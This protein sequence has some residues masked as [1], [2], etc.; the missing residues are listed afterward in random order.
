MVK[1]NNNYDSFDSKYW[2]T[3]TGVPMWKT[4]KDVPYLQ[5]ADGNF[6]E[7]INF[8]VD[9]AT[10][11]L[12]FVAGVISSSG[13]S[14]PIISC[15]N[16]NVVINGNIITVNPGVY[17]ATIYVSTPDALTTNAYEVVVDTSVPVLFGEKVYIDKST[18]KIFFNE[19]STPD[20]VAT[21][22]TSIIPDTQKSNEQATFKV[23]VGDVK[24]K[25][26]NAWVYDGIFENTHESR[27]RFVETFTWDSKTITGYYILL[28]NIKFDH[29]T[30]A[31]GAFD[32]SETFALNYQSRRPQA[33]IFMAT[34]DGRGYALED[35]GV[36]KWH[37]GIFGNIGDGAVIKNIAIKNVLTNYTATEHSRHGFYNSL[38]FNTYTSATAKYTLENVYIENNIEYGYSKSVYNSILLREYPSGTANSAGD[39]AFGS[40]TFTNVIIN[41]IEVDAEGNPVGTFDENGDITTVDKKSSIC[42]A[43][44]N[45][46]WDAK[47][48]SDDCHIN[49]SYV[50]T[51]GYLLKKTVGNYY[52]KYATKQNSRGEYFK[53][54]GSYQNFVYNKAEIG[55]ATFSADYWV[56]NADGVPVWKSLEPVA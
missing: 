3:M 28:E 47:P 19:T 7:S 34:L 45:I 26:T 25:F 33:N 42:G 13:N 17:S 9:G 48:I 32:L 52:E 4:T 41:T 10:E 53:A 54:Y 8:A 2:N 51:N 21:M 36:Y 22:D 49:N 16:P 27:V 1:A 43:L 56:I 18:G 24:Y 37:N 5:D 44:A 12:T 15:D 38:L 29:F 23:M 40:G 39:N 14:N 35:V 46:N 31:D 11:G 20:L 50:I 6:V 55:V 30:G